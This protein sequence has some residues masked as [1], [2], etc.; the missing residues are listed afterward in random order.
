MALSWEKHRVII[1][2]L[3]ER[4]RARSWPDL[5]GAEKTRS[6]STAAETL[7]G[8]TRGELVYLQQIF[9]TEAYCPKITRLNSTIITLFEN[10]SLAL[11]GHFKYSFK[12][13]TIY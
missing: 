1:N 7:D 12:H 6:S 4:P 5:T 11:C 8:E 2:C 3:L 9:K 10:V 13:R